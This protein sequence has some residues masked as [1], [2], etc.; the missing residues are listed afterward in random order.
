MQPMKPCPLCG[1]KA[2]LNVQPRLYYSDGEEDLYEYFHW[3]ECSE[4]GLVLQKRKEEADCD[5]LIEQWNK[6]V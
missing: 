2:V 5:D 3:I 4:C 1:N 6:R